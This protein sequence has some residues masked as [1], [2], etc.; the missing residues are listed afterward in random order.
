MSVITYTLSKCSKCMRCVQAC[1]TKAI[2]MQNNRI[3]ID[4]KNCINCFKCI[5]ACHHKGMTAQGSTL[6]DINSYNYTV[7]LV[8]SALSC[9]L[10][11][12]QK[13]NT[14]FNALKKLGFD[15][16]IDLSPV[17]AAVFEKAKNY[18][19][20]EMY[21]SSF[22]PLVNNLIKVKFPVLQEKVLPI[23]YPSEIMA[24]IRRDK[25]KNEQIGIFNLCECA[26]KL[27]LAKYPYQNLKYEV[28]HAL[29]IVDI[30]P[31]IKSMMVDSNEEVKLSQKGLSVTSP[32]TIEKNP[33]IL[34]TDGFD[35][36][37]NILELAEFGLLEEYNLIRLYPCY[38]GCIG[39][40]LMWG[41]AYTAIKNIDKIASTQ[42]IMQIDEHYFIKDNDEDIDVDQR[43]IKEKI[44]YFNAVNL[45]LENLP[46]YDCTACGLPTCRIMAEEIVN[47]HK[48]LNDCQILKTKEKQNEN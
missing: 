3:V 44:K 24:K 40:H 37:L 43:S 28:D 10:E 32:L 6:D 38:G 1:P 41:N 26:A 14:L 8:P 4:K 36:I 5:N 22:C 46:G 12:K 48:T 29:S 15:E 34:V 31:K 33:N 23:N 17:E 42:D 39:G 16:I 9:H 13:V 20:K 18:S 25:Y 45:Q 47:G 30:F 35:S 2:R 11:S 21:I 7:C 19:N 27:A